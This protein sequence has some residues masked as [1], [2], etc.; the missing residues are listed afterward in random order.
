MV[1]SDQKKINKIA[2]AIKKAR[3][4]CKQTD[5]VRLGDE[6]GISSLTCGYLGRIESGKCTLQEA[7]EVAELVQEITGKQIV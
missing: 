4:S 5:L 7:L 6:K 2:D 3:G 1:N